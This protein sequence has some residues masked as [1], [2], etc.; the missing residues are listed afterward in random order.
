M[1]TQKPRG[2]GTAHC[3]T[4]ESICR[5]NCLCSLC[6][7]PW[8]MP[9]LA[10][11]PRVSPDHT[12]GPAPRALPQLSSVMHPMAQEFQVPISAE[13]W[14]PGNLGSHSRP[15]S[16]HPWG[17]ES[18]CRTVGKIHCNLAGYDKSSVPSTVCQA[19]LLS[20]DPPHKMGNSPFT[21]HKAAAATCSGSESERKH[22]CPQW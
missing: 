22:P 5:S 7:L 8:H 16:P 6:S 21:N 18:T 9:L 15:S 3:R 1:E 2:E 10:Q 17:G 20:F 19:L 11:C 14:M 4:A 12:T 13:E